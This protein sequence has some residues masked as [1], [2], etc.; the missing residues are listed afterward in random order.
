MDSPHKAPVIMQKAHL[1]HFVIS[2]MDNHYS[3]LACGFSAQSTSNTERVSMRYP[4]HASTGNAYN[5]PL[6]HRKIAVSQ[7]FCCWATDRCK[8]HAKQV[9]TNSLWQNN[10]CILSIKESI[11]GSD[12]G[13]MLIKHQAIIWTNANLFSIGPSGINF[14]QI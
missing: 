6:G 9:K 11:I 13:L 4:H 8:L 7:D 3:C 2:T 1:C 10:T 12:N 5:Y 14:C